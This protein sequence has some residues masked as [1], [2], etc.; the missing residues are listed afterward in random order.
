MIDTFTGSNSLLA[1][2]LKCRYYSKEK[3]FWCALLSYYLQNLWDSWKY[4]Q[5]KGERE[6]PSEKLTLWDLMAMEVMS[7]SFWLC[8]LNSLTGE[9]EFW[10][11]Q[12]L[13]KHLHALSLV[14]F[15]LFFL[16]FFSRITFSLNYSSLPLDR[17]TMDCF[18]FGCFSGWSKYYSEEDSRD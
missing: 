14:L 3:T 10:V 13:K 4:A 11:L 18:C 8:W 7:S 12:E 16:F 9:G 6:T 2:N 17:A 1:G 15:P 5:N